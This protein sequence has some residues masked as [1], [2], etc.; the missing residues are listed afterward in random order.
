MSDSKP[1]TTASAPTASPPPPPTSGTRV[2]LTLAA[3]V[4]VI[5]GL[6][7]A[8]GF[9]LPLLVAMFLAVISSP[10]VARM[11]R[12]KVPRVVAIV[13]TVLVDVLVLAGL[14]ALV[15]TSLSGFEQMVPRYQVAIAELAQSTVY[16]LRTRGVPVESE[17]LEVLGDPSWL[18]HVF[19]DV[20]RELTEIVSNA[21]LVVLLVVFMLFEIDPARTKLAML[22]GAPIGRLPALAGA[23]GKVQRYLV[24]KTLLSTITGLVFGIFLAILGVDFPVLWGLAAF[25]LNYIPTIGPAIATIPPVVIA[26]LTLGPGAAIGAA[27]G[28]LTTN[29]VIGN[30]IEPRMMGEALGLSTLVVFASMLFW[31]WLWGPVGALLAVPLT[32]LLRD[33]LA[34]GESTRWLAAILGSVEWLETQREGWGWAPVARSSS[35]DGE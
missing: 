32:M 31:G 11:Q 16:N 27:V 9:F 29:V 15:A 17:D 4:I 20:A 13:L 12:A 10:L 1:E 25:L 24:V 23:V 7:V 18:L 33:A 28:L 35:S 34:L 3:I 30:V 26:L 5:S 2:T 19:G 22:L 8:G 6:R 21:L 14:V